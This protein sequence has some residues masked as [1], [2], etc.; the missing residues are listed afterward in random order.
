M[1]AHNFKTV[2]ALVNI[3]DFSDALPC[4][5][6]M[7]DYRGLI[8]T[9]WGSRSAHQAWRGGYLMHIGSVMMFAR[10]IFPYVDHPV[11]FT[12]N[13]ALLVLFW[14]DIEKVFMPE[15]KFSDKME[16]RK[17]RQAMF[18]KYKIRMTPEIRNGLDYV[19]G[20]NDDY[21]PGGR[22]MGPL[23]AFCHMCDTYSA[24]VIPDKK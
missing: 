22:V 23:A 2:E 17:F 9:A 18:R 24:R 10:R 19:E 1:I 5:S 14:H 6:F 4:L 11:P 7:K 15:A 12:L 21:I 3:M 13:D 16:R 20:E 8:E